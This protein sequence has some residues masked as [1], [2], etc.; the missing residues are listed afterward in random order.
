MKLIRYC[1]GKT[2]KTT[3]MQKQ[4]YPS[5][6]LG[7]HAI[8]VLLL[9]AAT[10]FRLHNYILRTSMILT[11]N[12]IKLFKACLQ[13]TVAITS[14]TT[15]ICIFTLIMMTMIMLLITLCTLIIAYICRK[16]SGHARLRTF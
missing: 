3:A 5:R 8:K 14:C 11:L 1:T 6:W 4:L 10:M 15:E 9:A 2:K 16:T 7:G 13:A 12:D